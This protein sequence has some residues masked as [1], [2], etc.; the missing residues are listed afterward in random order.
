MLRFSMLTGN[1]TMTLLDDGIHVRRHCV[2][3][4]GTSKRAGVRAS[5]SGSVE[6]DDPGPK[7]A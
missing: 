5:L 3:L 6:K 7:P 4:G 1:D 2:V